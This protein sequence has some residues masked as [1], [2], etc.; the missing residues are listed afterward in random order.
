MSA[1]N[2]T[3]RFADWVSLE[4][5]LAGVP[6]SKIVSSGTVELD[7]VEAGPVPS[8]LV[9][10]TVNVY[11]VPFVRPVTV[12]EVAEPLSTCVEVCGVEPM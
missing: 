8:E 1:V 7:A 4:S 6:K 3:P 11:A 10:D 12:A 2:F 5:A 9:A